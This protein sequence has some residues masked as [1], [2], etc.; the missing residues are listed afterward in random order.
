[1]IVQC[2]P[3]SYRKVTVIWYSSEIVQG[4]RYQRK[5]RVLKEKDFDT[6]ADANGF[7][8]GLEKRGVVVDAIV[9]VS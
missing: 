4:I 3:S 9:P 8:Q 7:A 6:F 5:E 2:R 1:M